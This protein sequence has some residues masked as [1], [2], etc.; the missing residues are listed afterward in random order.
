MWMINPSLLCKKHLMGEH[1]EI[2]K[3][4]HVFEK[5]YSIE[6][7]KGQIEPL[8]MKKRHDEIALEMENRGYSHKSPYDMPSLGKYNNLDSFTVD[9]NISLND[10]MN[11]C[12]HCKNII[13]NSKNKA[14]I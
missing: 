5:G 12:P 1:F 7:R 9:V 3:H 13:E 11:R 10:L 8:A 2:H 14:N 6:G 4:R